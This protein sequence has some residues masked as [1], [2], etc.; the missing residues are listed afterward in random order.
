MNVYAM[1]L[2]LLRIVG[3]SAPHALVTET[4]HVVA[5]ATPYTSERAS[6]LV[7]SWMESR[8]GRYGRT[9]FGVANCIRTRCDL[10][11]E[12]RR[13]LGGLRN[14]A[15]V[16]CSTVWEVRFSRYHHGRMLRDGSCP[17][18]DYG[19]LAARLRRQ[20]MMMWREPIVPEATG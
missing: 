8:F 5:Q 3:G 19:R 2:L 20:V 4:A 11:D 15:G 10:N 17:V 14:A 18:D 12:A 13:A 1:A 9:R 6:L 16:C 7:V